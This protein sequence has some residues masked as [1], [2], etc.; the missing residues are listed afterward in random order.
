[1]SI[2]ALNKVTLVG[3]AE[4]KGK[5]L[6][7]LQALGCMH[8][9]PLRA[10]EGGG[11]PEGPSGAAREALTFLLTCPSKR[12]QVRDPERFE[13]VRIANETIELKRHLRDL[14][15]ERD[16]LNKRIADLAPWGDF[17]LGE[18]SLRNGLRLWFYLVPHY[19]LPEVEA[20]GVVYEVVHQDN[21]FCYTVVISQSEPDGMPVPRTHTGSRPRHE[22]EARL[23]EVELEIED[24]QAERV[25]LTRWCTLFAQSLDRL[26][27]RADRRF[28]AT[29]TDDVDPLFALQGWA[30]RARVGEI[31]AYAGEHGMVVETARPEPDEAP[32][33]LFD[34]PQP[35]M[36]GQDLVTFYMTPG[37]WTWDPS[38]VVLYSFALFF[39]MILADAGYASILALILWRYWKPMAGSEGG[40]RFRTIFST[41]VGFSLVYGVLAG[42]YFGIELDE[43]SPLLALK[44]IDV[45][46][47]S[48]MMAASIAIG[49]VHLVFANLM[50][51]FRLGVRVQSLPP[52]GWALAISGG[53]VLY[54]GI[55][56]EA[57]TA[58]SVG[59]MMLVAGLALVFL[60]SGSGGPLSRLLG[61]LLALFKVTNAFGDVMS[62]LRLFALGLATASLAGAFNGMAAQIREEV[63]GLGVLAAGLVLL[64]G[65]TMNFVLGLMSAVVHGL[66]LNV[67]EFFN[68][69][70]QEE[71]SLFKPFKKREGAS[72]TRS[73]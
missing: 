39:A 54:A 63:S 37:Y 30:P 21:R 47:P 12:R 41:L 73:S 13:A 2:V 43:G 60:F 44:V 56:L 55:S 29:C 26:E 36:G 71:G 34:N 42:S 52:L 22:L 8:L 61:G 28:A 11:P 65:H 68:W 59:V 62:Y 23:E 69:G 18:L 9:I 33:T 31:E 58:E 40:A 46:D 25:S 38:G 32:P 7:D 10:T 20:N 45:T 57:Q 64:I 51:A 1:M 4:D 53:L 5:V 70:L 49:V 14:E 67:I 19:Q 3:H 66:R 48:S 50:N 24:A 27:D 72:W 6:E 16:F 15:D 35:V 17:D